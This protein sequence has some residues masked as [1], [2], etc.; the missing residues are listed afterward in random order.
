MFERP[1][2]EDSRTVGEEA[3]VD[4]AK[5]LCSHISPGTSQPVQDISIAGYHRLNAVKTSAISCILWKCDKLVDFERV[6]NNFCVGCG[7]ECRLILK[8]VS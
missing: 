6:Q 8:F 2:E 7:C 4:R 5:V 3:K 1:S